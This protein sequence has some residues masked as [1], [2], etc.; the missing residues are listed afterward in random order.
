MAHFISQQTFDDAVREN[1]EEFGLEPQDALKETI[2]QF[3]AQGVD[4]SS[5]V[6]E[7]SL[8]PS[9]ADEI[10]AA[11]EK[12]K[13]LNKIDTPDKVLMDQMDV[14]RIECD[15]GL[16]NKV[17]VAKAGA[18]DVLLDVLDTKRS[19]I[20]VER[21]CLKTL[22]SLMTKQPDLL[23]SRGI[24]SM[25]RF[26]NPKVDF[27][28]KKLTLRWIKECCVMHEMNRQNIFNARVLD[29]LKDLLKDSNPEIIR[30]VMS[31]FRALILDDDVRVE[32]GNAH[33]H[34]RIIASEFLCYL[35]L[36]M[37]KYQTD[38]SFIHD[39]ILTVTALMVRN[40]FCKKVKDAGGIQMLLSIMENFKNNE[41]VNRQCFKLI[42]SLAGNDDCKV[43]LIQV[44]L[45][46]VYTTALEQNKNNVN[47]AIAGLNAIAALALRS[48]ENSKALFEA[49]MHT[50]MVEIM[51]L[52]PDEKQV[53]KSASRAIRNMVSRSRYQNDSFVELG[54]EELLQKNLKKFPDIEYD[55]K[56]ALRDLGCNVHLKEEWTGKGGA[57]TTGAVMS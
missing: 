36:L 44:G 21:I 37:K 9:K 19:Y 52:Y 33:E 1:I 51:K 13:E 39:L 25:F 22:T 11:I 57:L 42:K 15:K 47:T 32:F 20:V 41:R 26:L 27:D 29:N 40:E 50:V 53:Q 18:Y 3:E 45:A 16:T 35:T 38:E 8:G 24:Q 12:L 54:V 23:D 46:P 48:P 34:A 17:A 56:A 43:Y 5:I 30:E 28:L 31:V 7:L 10:K 4:L 55:T 2:N 6:K 49:N 14:I